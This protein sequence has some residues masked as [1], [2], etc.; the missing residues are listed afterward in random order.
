MQAWPSV[1]LCTHPSSYRSAASPGSLVHCWSS[2][3]C[4]WP[5]MQEG[6]A[7]H[8]VISL[9]ACSTA[10]AEPWGGTWLLVLDAVQLSGRLG[11]SSATSPSGLI[12]IHPSR[13]QI[14][15]QHGDT[16][17]QEFEKLLM[18]QRKRQQGLLQSFI[19]A[20]AKLTYPQTATLSKCCSCCGSCMCCKGL[21]P[22][23]A[24][25]LPTHQMGLPAPLNSTKLA[26]ACM[27]IQ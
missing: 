22:C 16:A 1:G 19:R 24:L 9:P 26:S 13:A 21:A 5:C 6:T 20:V 25:P 11:H 4:C 15:V 12:A 18:M 7:Q 14:Q 10:F 2:R 23:V 27:H 3:L 8:N 17:S